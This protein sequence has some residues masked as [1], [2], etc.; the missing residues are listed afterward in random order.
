MR[1]RARTGDIA[2]APAIEAGDTRSAA[3]WRCGGVH[4][5]QR[6]PPADY[7]DGDHHAADEGRETFAVAH[8][9]YCTASERAADRAGRQPGIRT[10]NAAAQRVSVQK[11]NLN[12][13]I[14]GRPRA[15][16]P[17]DVT[18]IVVVRV[19]PGSRKGPWI[20]TGTDSD[21]TVFVRERAVDGKAN[22]A[23]IELLAAHY[24]VSRGAVELISGVTSRV[25]RFRI[26]R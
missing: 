4:Q 22:A 16:W 9:P 21:L 7:A 17:S 1:T 10:E 6:R 24:E 2:D 14:R 19:K 23:V 20:E 12:R 8:D 15:G 26:T 18:D 11:S 25:K 13:V 3:G 5:V